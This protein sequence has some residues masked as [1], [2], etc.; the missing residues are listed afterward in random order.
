ML[1]LLISI[2]TS[3]NYR[4]IGGWYIG[5]KAKEDSWY[6]S[7]GLTVTVSIFLFSFIFFH[8]YDSFSILES[9]I[10]GIYWVS[11]YRLMGYDSYMDFGDHGY[12]D[13]D[14]YRFILKRLFNEKNWGTFIYDFTGMFLRW[15]CP[16]SLA[17]ILLWILKG[18]VDPWLLVLG[19]VPAFIY[20]FCRT[21]DT[22]N[23][24]VFDKLRT[25]TKEQEAKDPTVNRFLQ[26]DKDLA[27]LIVGFLNGLIL[28]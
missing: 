14:S 3:L 22:K 19:S 9:L 13:D 4:R 21:F 12:K 26:K 1:N 7:R 28:F 15:F 18:I 10:M 27:E 24:E 20:L 17:F 23:P 16:S 8:R 6:N 11:T 25:S 5:G 2:F